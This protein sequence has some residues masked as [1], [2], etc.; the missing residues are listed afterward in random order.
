MFKSSSLMYCFARNK[1]MIAGN[2]KSNKTQSEAIDFV[3]NTINN[4]KYNADNV[5]KHRSIM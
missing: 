5:G 1:R 2:W 3:K 4:L